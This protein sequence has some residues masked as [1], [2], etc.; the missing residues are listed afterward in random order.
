M[1]INK[2]SN[3]PLIYKFKDINIG[4]VFC[5]IEERDRILMKVDT[6]TDEKG[7][8]CN[9]I[10]LKNGLFWCV[11]D[12]HQVILMTAEINVEVF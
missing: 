1:K 2:P 4:T 8:V 6:V 11:P 3:T 10:N 12:N 5:P 7:D 9:T